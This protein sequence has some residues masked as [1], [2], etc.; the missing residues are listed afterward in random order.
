MDMLKYKALFVSETAEYLQAINS[1][2]VLLEQN[3][4]H[5][6]AINS[7]FR[8]AH[9]IKGMAASM[10]F[11]VIRDLAHA[12]EDL[13]DDFR[14]GQRAVNREAIDLIFEGL[15]LLE[16]LLKEAAADKPLS[17][18]IAALQE[19]IRVHRQVPAPEPAPAAPAAPVVSEEDI[20]D[21]SGEDFPELADSPE[22]PPAP[23]EPAAPPAAAGAGS[24]YSQ[25]VVIS[26]QA[27]APSIRG[28][29]LFKRAGEL[30]RVVSSRPS[31]E[32]VKQNQFLDD[33]AGLA[34]ELELATAAGRD[35]VLKML[36]SLAEVQSF[37]IVEHRGG[38]APAAAPAAEAEEKAAPE[39]G[40]DP[41]AAAQP[42]PQTVRVKTQILDEFINAVGEMILVKS[43]LRELDK[44]HPTPGLEQ[45]LDRLE[46]L[47][48]DFHDLVMGIRLMPLD[49]V[50]ARLPRT[51]R[52]LARDQNKQVRF[53]IKGKE[54]ELDRAILEQLGDPL[55][56]LLRN[57][58]GHG[59]ESP[60]ERRQAGKDP[61]G[62]IEMLAFREHDMVLLEIR[63][64]GRG[65]DP[66]Q[67]KE[68]AV[69][70]Q[71]LKPEAA[72]AL[73]DEDA[74]QLIFLPG[75]STAREVGLVSGRGVG[76]DVVR[77]AV[78]GIGGYV[79]LASAVNKGTTITLHLP[80]TIS[81]ITVLL[82]RL[83]REV[84]AFPISKVQKTV[85]ILEHQI[86][87]TQKQHYFLDR[88]ELIPLQDLRRFLNLPEENHRRAP[89]PAL[90]VEVQKR[91]I[92][93][94]VD[95]FIGQEEAFIRP[96]GK[97]LERISGLSGVTM[98]GDG[99]I[100]FVLDTLGL[101]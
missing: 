53:E 35:E 7:L 41:F 48:R 67:L 4:T 79:S 83:N 9:S 80:R 93:L 14:Q 66:F 31:L 77:S 26:R 38:A 43:E 11:D 86:R 6:E 24:D 58:V 13:M 76:M 50:V 87:K 40:P 37:D 52:D 39:P 12:L 68:T 49:S 92:A 60:E 90:V 101:V 44:R 100:V 99:R 54:I 55:L 19:K 89:Y 63:D 51:V 22:R 64:D 57:A 8:S 72:A 3:P 85:E 88:Q 17:I 61:N 2:L 96:L 25:K 70:K 81:I 94:M 10:G 15:D 62:S 78:E 34:V 45:G 29:I 21:L 42:L 82:I 20:P 59:I 69:E 36:N 95:E 23:A 97:P 1:D 28:L 98:L 5:T 73:S 46:R 56:H 65:M 71:L 16:G 30:G 27:T 32:Q 33:P 91:K 47:I 84:F 74:Y 18:S 75:F